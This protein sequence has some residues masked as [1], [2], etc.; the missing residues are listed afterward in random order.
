MVAQVR[1]C[2]LKRPIRFGFY[3]RLRRLSP[4]VHLT[5]FSRTSRPGNEGRDVSVGIF[6]KPLLISLGSI[7]LWIARVEPLEDIIVW[8]CPFYVLL[9]ILALDSQ[10]RFFVRLS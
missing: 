8:A 2:D 7:N 9:P 10:I 4:D 3:A 6:K 5:D 1:Q